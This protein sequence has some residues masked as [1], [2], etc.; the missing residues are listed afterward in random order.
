LSASDHSRL[1]GVVGN[2]QATS[3]ARQGILGHA[4]AIQQLRS[5][6]DEEESWV[7]EKISMTQATVP[8]D[9]VSGAKAL[10]DKQAEFDREL[11]DHQRTIKDLHA[12]GRST[13]AAMA[14]AQ[15]ELA[16]VV[17]S[18]KSTS[19]QLQA[20]VEKLAA[21]SEQRKVVLE[22]NLS[23]LQ[24]RH[25]ADTIDSW[26]A[27][28]APAELPADCGRDVTNIEALLKKNKESE[29]LVKSYQSRI[30][31]L[32]ATK[33]QLLQQRNTHAAAITK[34]EAA[35]VVKWDGLLATL[36]ARE[37]RL[38]DEMAKHR[39]VE[40]V[41]RDFAK[42]ASEFNSWLQ[43]AEEDLTDPVRVNSLEESNR[44]KA[45]HEGFFASLA[46][47][48]R[49]LQGLSEMADN[50]KRIT[51][52]KNP[53]TWFTMDALQDGWE[54]I[55]RI[56]VGRETDIQKEEARQLFNEDKRITFAQHANTFHKWVEQTRQRLTEG[57]GSLEDQLARAEAIC[58]EV[59]ARKDDLR[60][61][62]GIGAEMEKKENLILDNRHTEHTT[63][64]LAQ[65]YDQLMQLGIQM[66]QQVDQLLQAKNASGVSEERLREIDK[67]FASFDKDRSGSLDILELKTCLRALGVLSISVVEEGQAD[68]EFK[69]LLN[70][71]DPDGDDL[72][73]LHEF[74]RFMI[75][76]ESNKVESSTDVVRAFAAA[77]G[78]KPNVTLAELQ[79]AMG[80][81]Q[82]DFC[83]RHMR[84][85]PKGGYDYRTF[86][87]EVFA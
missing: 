56:A 58:K 76:R 41:Q 42:K 13:I 16:D 1:F 70:Q 39:K 45:T 27:E 15:H 5:E 72:V 57:S 73:S 68:P 81:E 53:F 23:M 26:I 7:Q 25:E 86:V 9:Q 84:K 48:Q 62:E 64:G 65:G 17:G 69:A 54:N 24:Y 44:N 63:V 40:Q 75:D 20:N 6:F 31:K 30:D 22:D 47:Q 85:H 50:I 87:N 4:L 66:K 34:M 38:L 3:L 74:R 55:G 79:K 36:V 2:V 29:E 19:D 11:A 67:A 28:K 60:K 37:N 12:K 14:A 33:G 18:F 61:I 51:P 35:V 8:A 52:A 32:A 10:V 46:P 43:N 59:A 21:A 49:K 82:A 80:G 78:D 77:A 71:I 83:V